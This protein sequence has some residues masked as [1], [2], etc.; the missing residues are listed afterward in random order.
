MRH[1]TVSQN[2]CVKLFLLEH[3]KIATNCEGFWR[4]DSFED[5]LMLGAL[6]F[7]LT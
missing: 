3:C 6:I 5:K 2:N 4:K 7:H 1:Y